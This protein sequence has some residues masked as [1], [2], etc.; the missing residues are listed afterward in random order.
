MNFDYT[1]EPTHYLEQVVQDTLDY[2]GVWEI[3]VTATTC[4]LMQIELDSRS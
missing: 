1:N 3:A 4:R 2:P